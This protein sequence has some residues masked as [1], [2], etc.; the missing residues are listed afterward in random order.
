MAGSRLFQALYN[1]D[2]TVQITVRFCTDFVKNIRSPKIIGRLPVLR[3][4]SSQIF[5]AT[6]VYSFIN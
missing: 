6:V 5:R 1:R 3:E 4:M 2:K